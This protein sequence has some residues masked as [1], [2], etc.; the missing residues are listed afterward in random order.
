V[1][2]ARS[3]T[4]KR[5][6]AS[7]PSRLAVAGL[8]VLCAGLA[9]APRLVDGYLALQWTRHLVARN[10]IAPHV[11]DARSA[12]RW[13]ARTVDDLAPLPQ[14]W[15]AARLALELAQKLQPRDAAAARALVTPVREALER[16]ESSTVRGFGVG[17]LREEASRVE[18]TPLHDPETGVHP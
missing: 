5:P 18:N 13:A 17:T 6:A 9:F 1:A 10:A 8:I 4:Q 7:R 14:A 12:G 15:E 2:Q 11:Q 3:A 16:V